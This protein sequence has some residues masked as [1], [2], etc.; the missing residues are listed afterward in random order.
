MP[1]AGEILARRAELGELLAREEGK[2]R[3]IESRTDQGAFVAILRVF[4]QT[5]GSPD[6]AGCACNCCRSGCCRSGWP[7]YPAATSDA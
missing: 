4:V 2:P 6:L 5:L 3:L 7:W 1:E